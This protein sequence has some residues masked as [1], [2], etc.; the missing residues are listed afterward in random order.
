MKWSGYVTVVKKTRFWARLKSGEDEEEAMIPL[1]AVPIE[2][3]SLVREGAIFDMEVPA[4]QGSK[5][6]IKFARYAPWSEKEIR[7][8][9]RRAQA[10]LRKWRIV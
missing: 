2:D 10:M 8:A 7:D 3:R 1:R 9:Q 4:K 6:A 5:V